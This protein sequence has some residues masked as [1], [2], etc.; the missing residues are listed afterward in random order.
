MLT[1]RLFNRMLSLA[2]FPLLVVVLTLVTTQTITTGAPIQD[3]L[4]DLQEDEGRVGQGKIQANIAEIPI[5]FIAN[6]G[7]VDANVRFMVKAGKQTIF[8]TSEEVVF[9]ASEKREREGPR[10]SVV[11][12][13]FAGAN[14]EVKIEGGESLP[15]IANF[16]LG[17]DPE[18][19]RTNVPTYATITYQGLYPGIDLI[20]SGKQGR[21][22][23]QFVVTA[24]AN[25]AV[26]LMDYSGASSM[27]VREDGA[28]VLETPIDTLVEAPPLIYQVIDEE[29][30]LV[31]GGYRLL[32]NGEVAFTLGEYVTTEPLIIDP[33]LVYSTYLGGSDYDDG[34]G[35]TVDGSGNAYIIGATRSSNFP[36]SNPL[37]PD[38]G[39]DTDAFVAKLN[40]SGSGLI[41]STYL[42][43]SGRD[44]G[45]GIAVDS[46]GSAYITGFTYSVDFPAQDPLQSYHGGGYRDVFVAKLNASGSGLIYSTYLG[47]SGAD[48]GYG[49]AVDGSGNTYITGYTRSTDFP[50]QNP[51]Q[52]D[53]GGDTD[54]FV[55]KLNASG[56]TLIYSTYLGGSGRDYSEGIAAD[57]SGNAYITG[58][59][60]STDFPTYNPLQSDYSGESRDVFVAKLNTS[61]SGLI[62]STYLGGSSADHGEG[63][64]VDGS[65][66]AYIVGYTYSVD[67]PTKNPLQPDYGGDT[68][69]FVAKL[70][71][72]GSTLIY[73]TYLGGSGRDGSHGG[74]AADSSGNAYITGYTESYYFPTQ[75]P[76]QSYHGGGYRDAFVAKLN[77]S[78]S[79][80]VYSTYLGGSSDDQGYGIAVDS[81]GNAYITGYTESSN[82]P[83]QNP[84]QPDY[85]GAFDAFVVKL[86][87]LPVDNPPALITDFTASDGEDQIS[88]LS[89]TNPSDLDLAEVVVRRRTDTGYPTSHL[90]GDS[91][92][93]DLD[94]IPETP[95]QYIDTG[96]TNGLTYYYAVFSRD[97]A[98]NWNAVVEPGNNADTAN[99]GILRRV[100]ITSPNGGESWEVGSQHNIGWTNENVGNTVKLEYS[101]DSGTTWKTIIESTGNDGLYFW[102]IPDDQ[103]TQ[104]RVRVTSTTYP[105]VSD[106]SDGDFAIG[107][108]T[109]HPPDTKVETADIDPSKGTAK[110]TWSG[111]DDSTPPAQLVYEHRLLNPDSPLYDWSDWSSSTTATYPR[112]PD[113][114]LPDGTYRFQVKAKD[115]DG[116]ID[117]SPASRDF[118]IDAS[119][120]IPPPVGEYT[121]IATAAL[122]EESPPIP[123]D[124]LGWKKDVAYWK[125]DW[126]S[127]VEVH[128]FSQPAGTN[129]IDVFVE[130][131]AKEGSPVD[132]PYS[133]EIPQGF[134]KISYPEHG[135]KLLGAECYL[136]QRQVYTQEAE[137][138]LFPT[139]MAS[140]DVVAM[141]ESALLKLLQPDT[142]EED[143]QILERA[144]KLGLKALPKL[145][146]S[147]G[148][149][150][151]VGVVL[152]G[153]DVL[154][155]IN[156]LVPKTP[157][158]GVKNW[159][160]SPG[161]P[162]EDLNERDEN[163]YDETSVVWPFPSTN[164]RYYG[165]VYKATFR[166]HGETPPNGFAVAGV[167]Q[168][169]ETQS[170]PRE[171]E[172][173]ASI[174]F[175]ASFT[176]GSGNRAVPA[177][178]A[179]LPEVHGLIDLI[180]TREIIFDPSLG[181]LG[182]ATVYLYREVDPSDHRRQVIYV[183][184]DC[185]LGQEYCDDHCWTAVNTLLQF[186]SIALIV[187]EDVYVDHAN[188]TLIVLYDKWMPCYTGCP[189]TWGDMQF[190]RNPEVFDNYAQLES[191][192]NLMELSFHTAQLVVAFASI[193]CPPIGLVGLGFAGISTIA[194]L[195][196]IIEKATEDVTQEII[197]DIGE[198]DRVLDVNSF[199][200]I[201]LG[202]HDLFGYGAFA[203]VVARIPIY[204][205]DPD[206]VPKPVYLAVT[207]RIDGDVRSCG[208]ST[209][210]SEY[211]F[212]YYTEF[213]S[214]ALIDD[215]YVKPILEIEPQLSYSYEDDSG[216]QLR[217]ATIAV[218]VDIKNSK[219]AVVGVHVR[220]SEGNQGS[221]LR[222]V[223]YVWTFYDQLGSAVEL[224]GNAA[225][226]QTGTIIEQTRTGPFAE[227]TVTFDGT[228]DLVSKADKPGTFCIRSWAVDWNS[229]NDFDKTNYIGRD[230][231]P[232]M[233]GLE[234]APPYNKHLGPGFTFLDYGVY[235]LVL[236][237]GA[238][239]PPADFNEEAGVTVDLYNTPSGSNGWIQ[240]SS[241]SDDA[242]PPDLP[243]PP[244]GV[245]VKCID[246]KVVDI[247]SGAARIQYK[248]LDVSEV[249]LSVR[250]DLHCYYWKP[251]GSW[252]E[253]PVTYYPERGEAEVVIPVSELGGTPIVLFAC[254]KSIPEGA[255][256]NI[257]PNPVPS[258]GCVFWFSIPD[259]SA[260]ASLKVFN[261]A[262]RLMFEAALEP[263]LKRFP[264]IGTWNPV[265]QDEVPLA[266]GPYVYVL[267]ADGKVI[268]QGKMVIQR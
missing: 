11:R 243:I 92:Y 210:L 177:P 33:T 237:G 248:R 137:W 171:E 44:Y 16:F 49:I 122:T 129:Q 25:P 42:G 26:I 154:E 13:R 194:F 263:N 58:D 265:D 83:T 227:G 245:V 70:N 97:V 105:E 258:S 197:S 149:L 240:V 112:L 267:I 17:N 182:V 91:V 52:P 262:G 136:L 205:E 201:S 193:A 37:Q 89:W 146:R 234:T 40:A 5:S 46:S 48:H 173:K 176:L 95:V 268:G 79:G 188:S 68:D 117:G 235:Q 119:A 100:T 244:E 113:S 158:Q 221:H 87:D 161:F 12:L 212:Q 57:S 85:G 69:V 7:Q 186:G 218:R 233:V 250:P 147:L 84:L 232:E 213:R 140:Y 143:R 80:L 107:P 155:D 192:A 50:T 151:P 41:Y 167:V 165:L 183:E 109:N 131:T 214:H 135:I 10:S 164:K 71:A 181:N 152:S 195:Q 21:L 252:H 228:F 54:V 209:A 24:G 139:E 121:I 162:R 130:I 77:A 28:L 190:Q 222:A 178:L 225:L 150:K 45:E 19:W 98:G 174:G 125:K 99:P 132:S 264:S 231:G 74:I 39:G 65:G 4:P 93:Q 160:L 124:G 31:E 51:L 60:D 242:I 6:A 111:S 199:D 238:D 172:R 103:S 206:L 169:V 22:K 133:L 229:Y 106:T 204:V 63:I 116:A 208:G 145:N 29:R 241:L 202:W 226:L 266:N 75:D 211:H 156:K 126:N 86:T 72:S 157:F 217:C 168:I 216:Q 96:L 110:F 223:P 27:Y 203:S 257:G 249:D 239:P 88:L 114:R 108:V 104:C 20:Y 128:L 230:P 166:I 2:R 61:G 259:Y 127:R 62:Y 251:G 261:I 43:G 184:V 123:T 23:S 187:P 196:D 236:I 254:P 81:L 148:F 220:T 118:R 30:V 67:F 215:E 159:L 170:E 73:S 144:A 120:S 189:L 219:A 185:P 247:S 36:T 198:P 82:F 9:A 90:D 138:P 175:I 153:I 207:S 66:N 76:I 53:Y 179:P 163:R 35:I 3:I 8:F 200:Q 191:E 38:Y 55:A 134:I 1:L 94:P 18:K 15:G 78:G 255:T 47:G 256:V 115:A 246:V 142:P 64:A 141:D 59:T 101:V 102:T 14:G 180:G 32:G 224:Q 56:S 253:L 34:R 260:S